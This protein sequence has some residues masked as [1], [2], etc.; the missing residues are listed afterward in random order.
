[1]KRMRIRLRLVLGKKIFLSRRTSE[2]S[3]INYILIND[4]PTLVWSANMARF[5]EFVVTKL[6][7]SSR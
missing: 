6:F 3:L 4:L 5:R 1:M 7:R 2:N